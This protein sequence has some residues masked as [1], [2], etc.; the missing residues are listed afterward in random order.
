MKKIIY[1][2][3]PLMAFMT[4]CK[5]LDKYPRDSISSAIYF[6]NASQLEQY[7]NQF[8][9][10]FPTA[11][12]LYGEVSDEIAVTVL[13]DE[14]RG[15][16]SIP[17]DADGTDWNWSMLRHINYL[18]EHA[19]QCSDVE[20]ANQY[21]GLAY[22]FRAYFYY[23]KVRHYGDVPWVDKVIG[24]ADEKLYAERDKRNVV[25]QNVVQDLNDAIQLM[26]KDKGNVYR[27]NAYA[28]MALKS[29]ICLFEGTFCK[30]HNVAAADVSGKPYWQYM[31]TEAASAAEM[32]MASN[33]YQL[34]DPKSGE[35]YRDLF[36]Q[37]T[38][39]GSPVACEYIL[40]RCYNMDLKLNHNATSY[41]MSATTGKP[42]F[43]K[44]FMNQYLN[45]DGTRFTDDPDY[46]TMDMGDEMEDRDPRME[47]TVLRPD[48]YKRIGSDV[49]ASYQFSGSATGYQLIKYVMGLNTDAYNQ[50]DCDMPLF[51]YA[52]V[53]LNYAEAKAELGE[54]DETVAAKTIDLLR[55]RVGMPA[56]DV[57]AATN[58][59][60]A[61]MKMLYPNVDPANEGIILEI[62]RERD[63]EL[64]QEGFR[65]W[66]LMRW[67]EGKALEQPM[68]G[69]Y[70]PGV[71]KNE[72]DYS[73]YISVSDETDGC[74]F[75]GSHPGGLFDGAIYLEVGEGKEAILSNG[76]N[77]GYILSNGQPGNLNN[78]RKFDE[79]KDYLFPIPIRERVLS[80][81]KLTQNPGW[82]DGLSF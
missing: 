61:Y 31:L 67:K 78:G 49:V 52:E 79:E 3:V 70:F 35:P 33:A 12:D 16:R 8:Y 60:C 41:T 57:A 58:T 17:A 20:A 15:T 19:D 50:S 38:V 18:L 48:V 11:A 27:A 63:I 9:T 32:L 39:D 53:L 34:Y 43:T 62:R 10:I 73:G 7:S 66:D 29:R 21:K 28:A 40:A 81:G 56:M 82:K 6:K 30:Y 2:I 54:F 80:G 22:F 37:G 45:A 14:V 51:R 4:A 25:M 65:Y 77:G 74:A 72:S 36:T 24:S 55:K 23:D 68:L 47:Q 59:P 64:V 1:I 69:V 5:D 44:R 75:S 76:M 26:S 46:A 13:P 42:G 71:S